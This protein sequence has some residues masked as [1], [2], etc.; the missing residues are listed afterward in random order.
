[1]KPPRIPA[2]LK[3]APL[4]WDLSWRASTRLAEIV[5]VSQESDG[6]FWVHHEHLASCLRERRNYLIPLTETARQILAGEWR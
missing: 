5:E 2:Y 3:D 6:W 1:M 4:V